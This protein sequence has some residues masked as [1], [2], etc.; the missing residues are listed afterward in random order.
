MRENSLRGRNPEG[1]IEPRANPYHDER[2]RFTSAAGGWSVSL[3]LYDKPTGFDKNKNGEKTL[4]KAEQE[5]YSTTFLGRKTSDEITIK[6]LSEHVLDRAA[7]RSISP[8]EILDTL[9]SQGE[10]SKT[11][12]T[13]R[14]YNND[15][16]RTVVNSETGCLVAIMRWRQ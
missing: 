2:G 9:N 13:C 4:D 11:D 16:K 15:G 7:Q 1:N 3:N 5:R 14:V 12:V 10:P 8:G 6:S